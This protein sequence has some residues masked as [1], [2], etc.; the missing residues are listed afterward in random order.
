MKDRLFV[1]LQR[2]MPKYALTALFHRLARVRIVPF[3]NF[4]IRRFIALYRVDLEE[5]RHPVPDGF[6]TFNDF[7]IRALVPGAR[8]FDDDPDAIGSPADGT[9][10]AAGRIEANRLLQAKGIDYTL[11]DLLA[12]DTADAGFYT[13]GA[14]ATVYLAPY[15]YHRVHAPLAGNLV[16]AR[17]VPG[18]LFSVNDA[19]VRN[20]PGLFTANER[21]VCHFDTGAGPMIMILVGALNVGTINTRWTGDIRPRQSGVVEEFDI[22]ALPGGLDFA[23]GDMLGWFNMGSTVILLLPPG[24]SDEFAGLRPGAAVKTGETIGRLVAG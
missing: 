4:L 12:T 22:D 8:Q 19:T 14:F 16:A 10:S 9:V 21:L 7:F 11:E 5:L 20:L 23:C 3:K 1:L 17:Y 2:L 18:S 13:G 6:P 24:T 15:N